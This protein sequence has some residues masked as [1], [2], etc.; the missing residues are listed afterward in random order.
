[1]G[2]SRLLGRHRGGGEEEKEEHE[3]E[4][5]KGQGDSGSPCG[6]L[7]EEPRLQGE[8]HSSSSDISWRFP[9]LPPGT[10]SSKQSDTTVR[11]ARKRRSRGTAGKDGGGG[12]RG[13][14]EKK[15][16]I[17]VLLFPD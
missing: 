4:L 16:T 8:W 11:R 3:E 17:M 15:R 2:R 7:R 13:G 12:G 1:M 5:E 14:R 10:S 6:L 9:P